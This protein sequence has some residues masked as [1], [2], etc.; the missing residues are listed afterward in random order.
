MKLGE[1]LRIKLFRIRENG[2]GIGMS[3]DNKF[4]IV[5]DCEEKDSEVE[6][7]IMKMFTE[8]AFAKKIGRVLTEEELKP[9]SPY[10]MDE[11]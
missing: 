4:I 6:V 8:V 1:R 10:S 3:P 7:Q 11:E 5:E 9:N 2:E